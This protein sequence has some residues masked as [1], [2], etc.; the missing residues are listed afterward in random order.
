MVR[1]RDEHKPCITRGISVCKDWECA[2]QCCHAIK[3]SH[4]SCR[5]DLRNM[6]SGCMAC[7]KYWWQDH[8]GMII[9]QMIKIHGIEVYESL[10]H[11]RSMEKPHL[12]DLEELLEI[13][14]S[15]YKQMLN[16]I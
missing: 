12:R 16:N 14:E 3:R 10:R 9:A 4:K 8:D 1:L 7:N 6:F 2:R 11:N 13:R 15:E 5:R